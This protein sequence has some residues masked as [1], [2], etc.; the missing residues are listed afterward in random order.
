MSFT[1]AEMLARYD[2]EVGK[3][4]RATRMPED[5]KE[6]Y[7][8]IMSYS[9]EEV[10]MIAER[11]RKT[12][13]EDKAL[14][15]KYFEEFKAAPYNVKVS[16]ELYDEIMAENKKLSFKVRRKKVIDEFGD[17]I[18]FAYVVLHKSATELAEELNVISGGAVLNVFKELGLPE[19]RRHEY[20]KVQYLR[21]LV[22]LLLDQNRRMEAML[23]RRR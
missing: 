3:P 14:Q 9:D 8:K 17:Y 10:D 11:F 2:E 20:N 23:E 13:K 7:K 4:K 1:D 19:Q 18:R 22:M 6:F 21:K 15:R 12:M 16:Q 5:Y